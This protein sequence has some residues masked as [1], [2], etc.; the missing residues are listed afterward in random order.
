MTQVATPGPLLL[1]A[2]SLLSEVADD[3]VVKTVRDT[4]IAALDRIGSV[5]QGR[6]PIHRGSQGRS[7][8]AS[9]SASGRPRAG[10]TRSP[11]PGSG[12]AS[13]TARA[14]GS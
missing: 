10:S 1:D 8:E 9:A 4:H 12:R 14:V 7:T 11:P 13:R 3:L 6:N 5:T 2:L